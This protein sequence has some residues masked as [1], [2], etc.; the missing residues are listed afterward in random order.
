MNTR[1]ETTHD[2][3]R[4]Y[5]TGYTIFTMID[6]NP[7][8]LPPQPCKDTTK[9]ATTAPASPPPYAGAQ[10]ATPPPSNPARGALTPN[11]HKQETRKRKAQT[12]NNREN[13]N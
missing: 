4:Y 5:E 13:H 3:E 1:V 12:M 10:A 7:T 2:D 9:T 6:G 8:Q 11:K